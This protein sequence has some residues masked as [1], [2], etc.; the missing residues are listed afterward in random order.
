M[1]ATVEIIFRDTATARKFM[2]WLDGQGEQDYFEYDPTIGSL[3]YSYQHLRIIAV[4]SDDE[5]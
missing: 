5:E 2:T 4:D 1:S 3:K